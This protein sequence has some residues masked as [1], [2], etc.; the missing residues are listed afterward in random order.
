MIDQSAR[1]NLRTARH[2]LRESLRYGRRASHPRSQHQFPVRPKN[3]VPPGWLRRLTASARRRDVFDTK[4]HRPGRRSPVRRGIE[5]PKAAVPT[6]SRSGGRA[7]RWSVSRCVYGHP[8]R[9]RRAEV[10]AGESITPPRRS[11]SIGRRGSEGV[12]PHQRVDAYRCGH[13]FRKPGTRKRLRRWSPSSRAD[14]RLTET[15]RSAC[16]SGLR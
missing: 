15:D 14:S 4:P 8:S 12:L 16:A 5:N 1:H 10:V 11:I 9:R 13:E 7:R 3:M 6:A 2:V